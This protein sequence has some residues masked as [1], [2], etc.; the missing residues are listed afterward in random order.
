QLT[1]LIHRSNALGSSH[2]GKSQNVVV[3]CL[4]AFPSLPR[5]VPHRKKER[6]A[7]ARPRERA[8]QTNLS[9]YTESLAGHR[10]PS[11]KA[12]IRRGTH[13]SIGDRCMN[14]NSKRHTSAAYLSFRWHQR[15][16]AK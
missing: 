2:G 1:S 12:M 9:Y 5:I 3:H 15:D 8:A 6:R 4:D 11:G 16:P 10:G 7:P 14:D 13:S